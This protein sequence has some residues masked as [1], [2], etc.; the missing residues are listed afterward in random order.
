MMGKTLFI[1][2]FVFMLDQFSKWYVFQALDL[3]NK[4]AIDV[5]PPF[6]NFRMGWNTGINFGLFANHSE[7]MRWGLVMLAIGISIGLLVY[8]YKFT[9]WGAALL[10]GSIVGGALGNAYDRIIHGAV[11][12][13]LNMS[14]CGWSNPSV[15]N[16]ADIFVFIG[17]IGLL[18]FSE[19][20]HKRA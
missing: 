5:L 4:Y 10:F 8:A 7:L 11:A 2:V 3:E 18:L 16:V 15:F 12:D 14:C 20:L 9:G 1:S 6:L 13:F 19:K 17:A